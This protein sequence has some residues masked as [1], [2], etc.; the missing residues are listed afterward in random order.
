MCILRYLP[1]K[2][3]SAVEDGAGVV[4]DAGGAALGK[5]DD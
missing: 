3:P 5:R 2:L 4:V 1:R